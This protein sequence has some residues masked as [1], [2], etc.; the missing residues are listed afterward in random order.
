MPSN[1]LTVLF[2]RA[3]RPSKSSSNL[4]QI[5][6]T[7]YSS[8]STSSR[9]SN[10]FLSVLV[11]YK[12]DQATIL[13]PQR[14]PPTP[15]PKNR[16]PAPA[17]RPTPRTPARPV[18]PMRASTTPMIHPPDE[19]FLRVIR[20]R[21]ANARLEEQRVSRR[22]S[23][24]HRSDDEMATSVAIAYALPPQYFDLPPDYESPQ[25]SQ[26]T[27]PFPRIRTNGTIKRQKDSELFLNDSLHSQIDA[28]IADFGGFRLTEATPIHSAM[29]PEQEPGLVSP[30]NEIDNI[31]L[32]RRKRMKR[33]H[34][35]QEQLHRNTN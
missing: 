33:Q 22:Y 32:E 23:H 8:T 19:L 35:Q 1:R 16:T 14:T 24:A 20:R 4:S 13:Q 17:S 28:V 10:E 6:S 34:R 7:E 9:K 31:Y 30:I 2:D 3:L 18:S 25:Q 5:T 29:S 21:S 15:E 12:F 26:Q 11:E 27:K